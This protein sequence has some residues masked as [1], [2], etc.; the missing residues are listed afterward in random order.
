MT[1]GRVLLQAMSRG[2]IGS[3]RDRPQL[4]LPIQGRRPPVEHAFVRSVPER[5]RP[6]EHGVEQGSGRAKTIFEI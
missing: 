5:L 1:G 3:L 6:V 2:R 4:C